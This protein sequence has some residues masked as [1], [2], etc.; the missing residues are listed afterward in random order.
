L[1]QRALFVFDNQA[2]SDTTPGIQ[3][4]QAEFSPR[5]AAHEDAIRLDSALFSRI[6]TLYDARS[7]LGLDDVSVRLISRYYADFVRAGALL[8][9]RRRSGC[10]S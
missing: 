7:A 6:R 4:L 5:F 2:S 3:A 8:G 9:R 10:G 1:L